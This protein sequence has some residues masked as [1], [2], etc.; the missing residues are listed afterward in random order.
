MPPSEINPTRETRRCSGLG[1]GR[2]YF[3][4]QTERRLFF[5]LTLV[6]LAL[7]LLFQLGVL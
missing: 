2:I 6:M 1:G 4:R 7:G 3:S 5:I